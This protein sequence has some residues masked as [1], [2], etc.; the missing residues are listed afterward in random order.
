MGIS[1]SCITIPCR[2]EVPE[3]NDKTV[4]LCF[5]QSVVWKKGRSDGLSVYNGRNLDRNK[6][7]VGFLNHFC[8]TEVS[9]LI[10]CDGGTTTYCYCNIMCHSLV[11]MD[12]KMFLK[13]NETK[14]DKNVNSIDVNARLFFFNYSK[15]GHLTPWLLNS[16]LLLLN[17]NCININMQYLLAQ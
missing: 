13:A 10:R 9:F 17:V 5:N 11:L 4:T 2:F 1:G 6:I 7:Q 3:I 8:H 14:Y 16:S 15:R 12:V